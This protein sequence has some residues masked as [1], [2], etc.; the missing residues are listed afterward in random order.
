MKLK[1]SKEFI[2]GLTV[3]LSLAL[4]YW[5]FNFLKGNDVLSSDRIFLAKYTDVGGLVIANPVKINGMIVGQVRDMYFTSDG[6]ANIILELLIKN[7]IPVP[8]NSTA[9]IISSDLLGS[10][11]VEIILGDSHVLAKSGDTLQSAV[12]VSIKEE[13]NRQLQPL[14]NKAESLMNSI[15]TV[16]TMVQGLFSHKNTENFSKSVEHIA[17]SFNN[18]ESTTGTLDTLISGQ[19]RRIGRIMENIE[20]ITANIQG[21]EDNLNSIFANISSFSDTL[22][23]VKVSETMAQMQKTF[24]EVSEITRKINNGEGS[25]GMLVNNDSLYIDLQKSA[26]ELNILLEDIRMNPKKYVKVSVF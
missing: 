8:I 20:S 9:K 22:A 4:L 3:T 17:N 5:G 11:S 19:E 26:H 6:N 24:K 21:N 15:D 10:K 23:K 2:I 18:L 13:V 1:I 16:M 14:K 7:K 25:L 12:E